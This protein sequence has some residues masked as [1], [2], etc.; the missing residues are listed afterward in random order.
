MTRSHN[1]SLQRDIPCLDPIDVAVC[2]GGPAGFAAA[3]AAARLGVRTLL[4]EATGSLGGMATNG[5]VTSYDPMADGEKCLVGG[6]MREL[7]EPLHTR[8]FLPA[9]TQPENWR[10]AHL[11][12]SK[13]LPE[14]TKLLQDEMILEAGVVPRFFTRVAGVDASGEHGRING[15]ILCDVSGL[16]FQ[17][18]ETVIDC[19][20]DAAVAAAAGAAFEA[21]PGDTD[22]VMPATLCFVVSNVEETRK[23]S[24]AKYAEQALRDGHFS[25]T[26]V[27][28][29]P[30][31]IGAFESAQ[32]D[33]KQQ[34]K[35]AP[36]AEQ[37]LSAALGHCHS[38]A[39]RNCCRS[40]FVDA[41]EI[42]G[43]IERALT[44]PPP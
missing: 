16:C 3:I 8:K 28:L 44:S 22:H 20:G 30:S 36:N 31:Y 5:L 35:A 41:D 43:E 27:R 19:T 18:A 17:P 2:G 25:Q 24:P 9:C 12:P 33:P 32:P 6:I 26:E 15:L 10:K 42:L 11:C 1:Y 13:I 21:A 29:I 38:T 23:D 34:A 7:M 4:I 14:E 37:T 40:S 39:D